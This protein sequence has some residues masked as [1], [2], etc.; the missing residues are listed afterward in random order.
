MSAVGERVP[1]GRY[2]RDADAVADRR[3][4]RTAIVLGVLLA[5]AVS[6]A[7]WWYGTR[8]SVG[9]DLVSFKVLSDSR[10]RAELQVYKGA[11]QTVVCT[12]R[13]QAVDQSE[14]GRRQVT[15]RG[16]GTTVEARVTIRT[17]ARGTDA[18]LLGCRAL[19]SG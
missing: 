2:G 7:G 18:E 19:G 3:L 11:D 5:V 12:V 8:D 10:V 13:S 15:V 16:H 17:T 1:P 14:V 4:R 6:L 9:G